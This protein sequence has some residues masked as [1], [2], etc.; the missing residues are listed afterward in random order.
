MKIFKYKDKKYSI[1]ELINL[2]YDNRIIGYESGIVTNIK[3]LEEFNISD[4]S[5]Y[6][7]NTNI[8]FIDELNHLEYN[9][10]NRITDII[11][12]DINKKILTELE[13]KL[14]N[15]TITEIEIKNLLLLKGYSF[16]ESGVVINTMP[17]DFVKLNQKSDIFDIDI[18]DNMLGKF[19]R[20][21]SMLTYDNIIQKTNRGNSNHISKSELMDKLKIKSKSIFSNVFNTFEDLNLLKRVYNKDGSFDI[22]M[23]PYYIVRNNKIII[24][25]TQYLLFFKDRDLLPKEVCKFL[26]LSSVNI[27]VKS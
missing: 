6:I 12:N 10:R 4:I 17:T 1:T 11:S 14:E 5:N 20:L 27:R 8:D 3:T 21:L 7:I 16:S 26:D 15:D 25:K 13:V 19:T 18:S 24:D 9:A 22:V 23:N 2:H